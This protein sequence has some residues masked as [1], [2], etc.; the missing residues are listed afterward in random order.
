MVKGWGNMHKVLSSNIVV[1]IQKKKSVILTLAL[2]NH[3]FIQQIDI[4]N[5]FLSGFLAEDVYVT[6]PQGFE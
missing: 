6:Q 3:W 5:A 2:S 1:I 4:N